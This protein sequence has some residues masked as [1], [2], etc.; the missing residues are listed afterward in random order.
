MAFDWWDKAQH[1][2]AFLVLGGLGLLA[3]SEK[4]GRIVPGLLVYGASIE[5]AQ[6]A[7]GWSYG[8]WQDWLAVSVRPT[9]D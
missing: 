7:S 1:S 5:L 6:A 9:G 2:L 8:D 4:P 3:Y